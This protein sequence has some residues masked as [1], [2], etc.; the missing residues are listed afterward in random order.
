[1]RAL[2][3]V[4]SVLSVAVLVACPAF[5]LGSVTLPHTFTNGNVA[6]AA[7]INANLLALRNELNRPYVTN[8][9][10]AAGSPWCVSTGGFVVNETFSWCNRTDY[11][12]GADN[13]TEVYAA[14]WKVRNDAATTTGVSFTIDGPADVLCGI[15]DRSAV[16]LPTDGG[17]TK[18]WGN[19]TLSLSAHPNVI[20][21]YRRRYRADVTYPYTVTWPTRAAGWYAGC[22]V[23]KPSW[24]RE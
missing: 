24:V 5:M 10:L 20:D 7:Q 17:W 4:V 23:S 9:T 1:M 8:V 11:T 12:M 18:V 15:D 2:R 21:W 16:T 13:P 6:D 22:V 3:H 19:G 14:D